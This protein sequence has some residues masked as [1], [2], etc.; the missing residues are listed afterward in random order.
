VPCGNGSDYCAEVGI[1][2]LELNSVFGEVTLVQALLH[3]MCF[4]TPEKGKQALEVH[5]RYSGCSPLMRTAPA[6][7]GLLLAL[8][9]QTDCTGY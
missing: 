2:E 5:A 8:S 4:W 1:R 6:A 3:S 7:V 9:Q